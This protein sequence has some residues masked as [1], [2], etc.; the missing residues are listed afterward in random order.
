MKPTLCDNCAACCVEAGHQPVLYFLLATQPGFAETWADQADVPRAN[1]V[2]NEA[3][4]VVMHADI[5]SK[6]CCWLGDDLLCKWYEWRP[7]CCRR[8]EIGGE[9]CLRLRERMGIE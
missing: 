4:G 6:R 2:P 5:R 8:F 1:A 7:E 3:R 9:E